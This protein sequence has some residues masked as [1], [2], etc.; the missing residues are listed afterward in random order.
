MKVL[1][2]CLQVL[3]NVMDKGCVIIHLGVNIILCLICES[4]Q[5]S[6]PDRELRPLV[7]ESKHNSNLQM[8]LKGILPPLSSRSPGSRKTD[9]SREQTQDSSH[10]TPAQS[11]C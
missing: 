9:R 1:T 8:F 6:K 2:A 5:P 7:P 10:L 4:F 3:E 11:V